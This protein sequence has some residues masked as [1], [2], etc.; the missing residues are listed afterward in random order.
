MH[1]KIN[2]Y[3][4]EKYLFKYIAIKVYVCMRKRSYLKINTQKQRIINHVI[5]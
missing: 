2:Y 3:V 1:K 5:K 4:N